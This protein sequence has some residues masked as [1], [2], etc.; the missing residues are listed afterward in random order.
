V[1]VAILFPFHIAAACPGDCDDSGEVSLAEVSTV[2]QSALTGGDGGAC[3]RADANADGVVTI[4]DAV[5]A[6]AAT[7]DCEPPPVPIFP[8]DYR[9]TFVEVRNCRIG[10]EHDSYAVRVLANP[11]GAD[12]YL[13]AQNPLPVG[14]IV[15]KEEYAGTDCNNPERLARWSVMR[16]EEPGFDPVDADW[17]WQ[18]IR[19]DGSLFIDG[20][21]TCISCHRVSSC[22]IRDYMCLEAGVTTTPQ[23][24]LQEQAAA[25]LSVAGTSATD[26][27]VVGSDPPNDDFGPYVLHYDGTRWVR[28]NTGASGALWW[29][30]VVPISGSFY[31]SGENGLVLEFD[32][33][34]RTFTRHDIPGN[35]TLYGI[36]GTS[37]DNLW[38][39]GGDPDAIGQ[40]EGG[41]LWHFDGVAWQTVELSGLRPQGVPVLFKVWGRSASD[42]FVVGQRGLILHFDGSAW[43]VAESG[44]TRPLFTV[45]GNSRETVAVGGFGDGVI[46]EWDGAR[47]VDRTPSF[48]KQVNGVFVPEQG[49]GVTAGNEGEINTRVS[50]GWVLQG[51][52]PTFRD[53]HATWVDPEGGV[54]AVGGDLSID[55]TRG[56][57]AYGGTRDVSRQIIDIDPC[58]LPIGSG[59]T[60][61][62]FANDVAPLLAATGCR[63]PTCHIG[64][65]PASSYSVTSHANVLKAGVLAKALRLCP[66]V[67]G[68]PDR[69]FLIEKLGAMQRPGG[70]A[71]MPI[72]VGSMPLSVEQIEV[73]RTW[74]L[75]GAQN[76]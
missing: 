76:N 61:V 64:A 17:H 48:A 9:S 12:G 53:F 26:V 39:V 19:T 54:W 73:L 31:M 49:G 21:A 30:S 57:V 38:A 63:N 4:E 7:T 56:M 6:A 72:G 29:V 34:T 37:A 70:G 50:S 33:T 43:R 51:S 5:L 66:V 13:R 27:Y 3:L 47:F 45:H 25:F 23:L 11:I 28:L 44:S 1:V 58:Q 18:R 41:V 14:T 68:D 46:L 62:S 75:E 36:W 65:F 67:P 69:S 35:D 10:L 74:I 32:L 2:I 52:T 71:Q 42:V 22:K 55:L 40:D 8:A 60:T 24:V 15:I 20:K 59:P 16:K